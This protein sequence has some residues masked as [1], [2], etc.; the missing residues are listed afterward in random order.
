ME[1]D[2]ER[3]YKS[4]KPLIALVL[5]AIIGVVGGTFAYFTSQATFAN[6]FKTKPYSTELTEEFDA[7]TDWLP[8]Q[9]TSKKVYVTNKG[10]IDLAVRI[11]YTEEWLGG[12]NTTK[13]PLIQTKEDGTKV[14]AAVINFPS[15]DDWIAHEEN[16]DVT[17]YYYK[18][19]IPKDGQTSLFID[20]VTFNKDVD[21]EYTCTNFYTYSDGTTSEG[22]TPTAGKTVKTT[23]QKCN[24]TGQTYAGATYTLT[25]KIETVQYDQ[26]K[27]YWGTT[28]DINQA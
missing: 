25:I 21:I 2:N 16:D 11:S 4:N 17:Y 22:A 24:S 9:E 8:G 28:V 5:L 1:Y 19:S 12:D 10:D 13:L 20:K 26:Y 23:T 14:T 18:D 6:I 3:S 15:Q 27:N 7:P